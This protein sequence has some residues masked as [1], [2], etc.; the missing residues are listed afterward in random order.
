VTFVLN[1]KLA[2]IEYRGLQFSSV[3]HPVNSLSLC[4]LGGSVK[5]GR[6]CKDA[7]TAGRLLLLL[8]GGGVG[9]CD[10][11]VVVSSMALLQLLLPMMMAMTAIIMERS[12]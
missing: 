1:R 7:A 12:C 4:W 10:C 11:G 2:V 5:R 9:G 8:Y 6:G 3:K